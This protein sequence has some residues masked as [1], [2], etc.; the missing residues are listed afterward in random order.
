MVIREASI[1]DIDQI[2]SLSKHWND[3]ET[4]AGYD[5]LAKY[6]DNEIVIC[7]EEDGEIFGITMLEENIDGSMH[8]A[9]LFVHPDYRDEGIGSEMMDMVAGY[10]DDNC[11][12]AFAS[13]ASRNPAISLYKR[14]NFKETDAYKPPFEHQIAFERIP[15]N[16]DD[17]AL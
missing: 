9:R 10:L 12:T 16:E 2:Q 5:V 7:A 1:D 13:V 8:I 3:D 4:E 14:Y 15:S 17:L 6:I 11:T